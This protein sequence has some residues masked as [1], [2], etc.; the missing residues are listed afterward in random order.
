MS[1]KSRLTGGRL[2][3]SHLR[4]KCRDEGVVRCNEEL[5][6]KG[7]RRARIDSVS[8]WTYFNSVNSVAASEISKLLGS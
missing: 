3:R 8:V 5:V 6:V 4:A 1:A 2:H 7:V